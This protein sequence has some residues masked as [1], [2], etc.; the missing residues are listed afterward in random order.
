MS[1]ERANRKRSINATRSVTFRGQT[2]R[3]DKFDPAEFAR[4]IVARRRPRKS[5]AE[6][7][8]EMERK[9]AKR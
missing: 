3:R 1:V 5:V 8:I 9:F 2:I 6:R 4:E 7:S